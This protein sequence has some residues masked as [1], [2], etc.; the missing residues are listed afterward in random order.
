[1]HLLG[2]MVSGFVF[3]VKGLVVRAWDLGSMFAC[4]GFSFKGLGCDLILDLS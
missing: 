2:L 1:M 3:R 4:L